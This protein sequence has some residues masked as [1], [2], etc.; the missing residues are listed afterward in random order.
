MASDG[1]VNTSEVIDQE[2]VLAQVEQMA[3]E[4]LV[5]T[6]AFRSL[7]NTDINSNSVEVPVV[8]SESAAS[9]TVA[10][11]STF[12]RNE[13]AQVD[14]VSISHD[15]YG[16]EVEITYEAIQ[17]SLLDVISMHTEDKARALAEG[18]DLA[19]WN[20]IS[21]DSDGD[22]VPDNLQDTIVGDG[23]GS[24]GYGEVVDAMTNL[25]DEGYDPDLLIV[26]AQSKGDLLKSAEFTRASEMGDEVVR[27]GA[28]GMI[29][30]I[31]VMVSNTGDLG[32][33]EAVM[34]DTDNYGFE[35]LREEFVSEQ[36]DKP[37]ENKEIVQVRTRRGYEAVR[38]TAGVKIE[39]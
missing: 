35:S 18:L 23:G 22:G 12:P 2:A 3:Q 26:S 36:Y 34:F 8:Q 33:G 7:D 21:D 31:E 38:P 15:K 29:A 32:A 4:N 14:K 19:A 9:S 27:D 17:D 1:T 24:L 6:E 5:F 28:F 10:E 25:E 16:E 20:V 39:G 11:G 30:G 37:E 13:D